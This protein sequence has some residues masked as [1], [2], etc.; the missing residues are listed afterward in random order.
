MRPRT[1]ILLILVIVVAAAAALYLFVLRPEGGLLGGGEDTAAQPVVEQE[2]GEAAQDEPGVT[3]PTPT[4]QRQFEDVV[5]AIVDLP[6]GERIRPD[7]I[8]VVQRPAENVAVLAGVTFSDKDEVLGELVRTTV[9]RGQEILRPMIALSPSDI[10]AMG[11]DLSLYIDQGEVAVAFPI[12]KFTGAAY[13]MRPGDLVDALMTLQVVDVDEEFQTKLP[14]IEQRV[15]ES[16]LLEGQAFLFPP[17]QQGRLELIPNL[18]SVALIGPGGGKEAIPR[19]V[20]QLTLQQME[21]LWVGS[22]R[23]PAEKMEQ[24]FSADAI[25]DLE[26]DAAQAILAQG[27]YPPDVRVRHEQNPDAVILSM[28]AQN[29]LA[30]KWALEAGIH[31]D[32]VLR[33]QG[34]VT[35][36]ATT[37]VTLP[38]L[39]EQ[40]VLTA[41]TTSD[42]SLEPRVEEVPVP[43]LP[44][45]PPG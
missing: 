26:R 25:T 40:G 39:F 34:D 6:V 1:L 20:T 12:D 9:G 16:A 21:V 24:E 27:S 4:L 11:S 41:P 5:V 15:N 36:F 38:Q 35:Q 8:E 18:N 13:A 31:I 45:N 33:A 2:S 23:D 29:A 10:T 22:W 3:P 19:R 28:T 37:S 17:T 7:L 42:V 30:L 32:L 44:V 14:N 43:F